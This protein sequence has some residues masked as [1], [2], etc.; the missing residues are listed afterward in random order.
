[1]SQHHPN[2]RDIVEMDG[3][4]YILAT[5]AYGDDR[6]LVLACGETFAVL[7][8]VGDITPIGLHKQG[9][10]HEGTRFLSTLLLRLGVRRLLLLSSSVRSDNAL[11]AVDLTNPDLFDGDHLVLPRGRLHLSRATVLW[12]NACTIRLVAAN[13]SEDPIALP[14]VLSVDSDFADIFEVRGARRVER[15]GR[16]PAEVTRESLV[17]GYRGRDEVIRQTRVTVDPEPS[18]VQAGSVRVDLALDPGAE[19]RIDITVS[20]ER[21]GADRS[22]VA[23]GDALDQ[24]T[25][26]LR[27][28]RSEFCDVVTSNQQFN[29]W[30]ERSVADLSM[31]T[32]DTP[33]GPYPYAGV[34][35]FS[36]PFGRDGLIT[37]FECLWANPALAR[38]VLRYLADTQAIVEDHDQ[39]AQPGKILHEA[40]GGEMANLREVPFGRYYGS[41][42]A[43]P[44]FVMLAAAYYEATADRAF[45]E[46]LMPHVDRA[47]AWMERHGDPDRDGFLEYCRHSPDGLVHQGW[48]DS[49]DAVFHGDGQ[50]ALA[51][52]ALCEVQAYAYAAWRGAAALFE[53][54]GDDTRAAT[55]FARAE[56]LRERFDTDFWWEDGGTYALALDGQKRPCRVRSSNA[57]HA[58]FTGIAKPARAARVVDALR[59]PDSF[60]G[61]GIRTLS[62]LERRYNPMSY[63]NGSV[64]P[65]DNA[66]IAMGLS[67]YGFRRDALTILGGLFDASLH[68]GLHRMPELFCG[69][70]RRPGESPT[71]YPVACAP[72][73][74]AAASVFMLLQAALGMEISAP[75]KR[76][77]LRRA[78]LPD[79]LQRVY[80]RG[81]KVGD[82]TLDLTL[83]RNPGDVSIEVNRRDDDIEIV[84]IK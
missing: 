78:R 72:Q 64:W 49:H 63:H 42:D 52:I 37:A 12:D 56:A 74:W 16:L 39:D 8:R 7:D 61:W 67:R 9:L 69:F 30:L 57:G 24:R 54:R 14:V 53:M 66:L 28:R 77:T 62:V 80:I 22:R 32:A 2:V 27:S 4:F 3:Q 65:H 47:L 70:P 29:G 71:L 36:T 33:A 18:A 55:L 17:L 84:T 73:A 20:C 76:L 15:G 25:D 13:Y 48:K 1:M 26:D 11:A 35:W 31:I 19:C 40:R 6:D 23:F 58:L 5:S 21:S 59:A 60:S 50:A 68:V 83:F 41:H 51:P 43:T 44:L 82:A 34:P 75:E 81:L 10:Y 46:S 38:G 45:I 79:F